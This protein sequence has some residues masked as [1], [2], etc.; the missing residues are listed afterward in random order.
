M[1][2]LLVVLPEQRLKAQDAASENSAE[3]EVENV[4]R[5]FS[6]VPIKVP[7][8][9]TVELVAGPPL[10]THPTMAAFDNRGRLYVCNNAGVNMNNEELEQNLPNS[11][12]Q[13]IDEDGDGRF[14]SFRVFADKMTFPMGGVWHDGSLFVASPPNIWR[15]TDLDD[16]GVAD[17]REIIVRQF[18]YTG[19]AASI[20]GCFM[21]PDGRLYWTDGYHGH[22]FSDGEGEVTSKREGSYLFSCLPDGSD[23]RIHCGGGMDNPVEVDFTESGDMLGTVNI[24][25][26]RPRVD[27][28]VHWLHGGAYPHRE[29][30]LDEI[31]VTGPLLGPAHRF[32]HVAVS[33][34]TRY[35]SGGFDTHWKNDLFAT[36]FNSGKVVRL[37]P[38]IKGATYEFTQH[39]F[40]TSGSR[41]FHPTDVLEDADGSLLVID[42]G[43]WFYRGCPT[44]Q[45]AKPELLGGIYRVRRDGMESVADPRGLLMEWKS[46]TPQVLVQR[47]A[48]HRHAVRQAACDEVVKRGS[49]LIPELRSAIRHAKPRVRRQAILALGRLA[50]EAASAEPA[51]AALTTALNDAESDLRQLACRCLGFSKVSVDFSVLSPLLRDVSPHVRRQ[52]QATVGRKR[53]SAGVQALA[54]CLLRPELDLSERHAIVYAL[55]EIGDEEILRRVLENCPADGDLHLRQR[56]SLLMAISQIDDVELSRTEALEAMF[57]FEEPMLQQMALHAIERHPEWESEVSSMLRVRIASAKAGDASVRYLLAGLVGRDQIALLAAEM[58]KGPEQ[59]KQ[60]LALNAIAEGSWTRPHD[61]W[62]MP[63]ADLMMGESIDTAKAGVMV[64]SRW[65]KSVWQEGLRHVA[66]AQSVPVSVKMDALAALHAGAVDTKALQQLVRLCSDSVSPTESARAARIIGTARLT[67]GQLE[68]I[69][70]LLEDASSQQLRDLIRPF[71]R[72]LSSGTAN[73]FLESIDK[74]E[75]FLTLP[76]HELSDVI[77]RFPRETIS[78]ANRLL[79]RLKVNQQQKRERL[80]ELRGRLATGDAV[81]GQ[82]LFESE[83]AKCSSCHR[84][85]DRGQAVGPDLTTI[86]ANRSATDLLESVVFPSASIVRDYTT[87]QV[88]T[89]H[90][91][92]F[93]GLLVGESSDV[94]RLQLP[95]GKHVQ[96]LEGDVDRMEPQ[97]VS[98]MPAGLDDLLTESELVDVVKYLQS[99]N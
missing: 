36:F 75:G 78:F 28:L 50:Q 43:G 42:T 2:A 69:L 33:G 21:G 10:V 51:V 60:L 85:G 83:K 24:L 97:S 57:E 67:D 46:Q 79:D 9:F 49:E 11:I 65:P 63:V 23:R 90:G 54:D 91:Q 98:V 27:C 47:F 76:E 99:L 68:L 73:R 55:V 66:Q 16:D 89:R 77:K 3:A 26:T 31:K 1:A 38:G 18:G 45:F 96:I 87:Y 53:I 61:S 81:R 84:V 6:A 44:S 74:A 92:V 25:Y 64:A 41:D 8:G 13:L 12:R 35:R 7:E 32:G 94:I 20:H 71:Q 59:G 19:N 40:L 86:G 17:R 34:M 70:P 88:L 22:E 80:E 14:D 37:K 52:A 58:L 15:L 56:Q 62:L 5:G 82:L 72:Q 93:S 39:E 4:S 29:R 48:D 95:N 30:V